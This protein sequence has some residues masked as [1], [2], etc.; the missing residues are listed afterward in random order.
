MSG[1]VVVARDHAGDDLSPSPLMR[2]V[3]LALRHLALHFPRDRDVGATRGSARRS[4]ARMEDG[5]DLIE[6]RSSGPPTQ[7]TMGVRSHVWLRSARDGTL[8]CAKLRPTACAARSS[9]VTGIAGR[10]DVR[11]LARLVGDASAPH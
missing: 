8:S 4:P 3:H 9:W 6:Q 7:L 2:H 1:S 5:G 10:D 11:H